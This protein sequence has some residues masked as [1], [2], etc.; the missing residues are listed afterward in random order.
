VRDGRWAKGGYGYHHRHPWVGFAPF[1]VHSSGKGGHRRDA[2]DGVNAQ[3]MRISTIISII[4]RSGTLL[5]G[6]ESG[7]GAMHDPLS[8]HWLSL[9]LRG[10]REENKFPNDFPKILFSPGLREVGV[11][12]P[13]SRCSRKAAANLPHYRIGESREQAH[14]PGGR[15]GEARLKPHRNPQRDQVIE[16]DRSGGLG[17][18]ANLRP[19]VSLDIFN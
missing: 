8:R 17:Y 3:K 19:N 16:C 13:P 5:R 6:K 9:K 2:A 10:E 7:L 12:P 11:A 18:W 15:N 1:G 14:F 4:Y